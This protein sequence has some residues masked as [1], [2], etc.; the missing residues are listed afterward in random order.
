M[1]SNYIK[2]HEEF[3]KQIINDSSV[4]ATTIY[5]AI[6]YSLFP[7]GKRIRP[8]LVYLT[9]NLLDLDL[10]ILDVIA[11]AIELTHCYSLIHDDLPAMDNDD[12]RRGKPSCHK[13]FDEATAILVG[14]GM[15]A[16]A[17]EVLLT[18]LSPLLHPQQ[19]I[20]ITLELVKASGISGMVSGQSL[21]LSEL[22]KSSTNEEQLREIHYLK[23]GRLILACIEMV[24]NAHS[25]PETYKEALRTYASHLGL[26][27]QM[28][29]DYLDRYAPTEVLGKGRSSDLA[30]QKITFAT[31]FSPKKLEEEINKH[32]QIALDALEIFAQK[33]L[34]LIDLT[35][36]L[37]KRSQLTG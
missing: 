34:P 18:H 11:A 6:N 19:V 36:K 23:T 27:F 1:I 5:S 37:Q 13:A 7:G 29:D 20:A 16:L 10:K 22:A 31:L 35:K 30:N 3:L 28:Q 33:A 25:A 4:P 17:I 32:Y 24:L 2:R 14:D 26:V 15:Q 9:G 8:I 21:D 12:L